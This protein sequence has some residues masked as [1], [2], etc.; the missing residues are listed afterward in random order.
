M[1][2]KVACAIDRGLAKI[3][4]AKPSSFSFF[5]ARAG[6]DPRSLD[7]E[8]RGEADDEAVALACTD[9][10]LKLHGAQVPLDSHSKKSWR[11]AICSNTDWSLIKAQVDSGFILDLLK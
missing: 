2:E 3:Y 7:L 6:G 5:L 1:I 11:K 10:A 4:Y 8:L 9:L